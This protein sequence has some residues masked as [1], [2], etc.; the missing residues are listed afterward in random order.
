MAAVPTPKVAGSGVLTKSR[1]RVCPGLHLGQLWSFQTDLQKISRIA[2]FMLLFQFF[3]FVF[4][5]CIMLSLHPQE[6]TTPSKAVTGFRGVTV[7]TQDSESCD[8][9]SNLGGTFV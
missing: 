4:H 1:E 8:P 2:T 9:S 5:Q 7:S 3:S 6:E